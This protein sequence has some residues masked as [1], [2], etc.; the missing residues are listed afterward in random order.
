MQIGSEIHGLPTGTLAE[1]AALAKADRE[2]RAHEQ[3]HL[4][5]AGAHVTSGPAYQYRTGPDGKRYAVAGEVGIDVAP[6]AGNPE[7]TIR[8][9]QVIQAAAN[10]PADPSGQDRA[11]AAQAARMEAKARLE[12]AG[13]REEAA[14]K[15][16]DAIG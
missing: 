14:G 3:A 7:A 9:A 2:V 11:V 10:A 4:A 8:K 6:V 15:I 16:I 1:I 13:S 12:L 5:A